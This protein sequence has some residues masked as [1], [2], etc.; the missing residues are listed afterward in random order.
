MNKLVSIIILSYN[1]LQYFKEALDSVLNQTY[2]PIELV[3][4]DDCSI[5]FDVCLH[6]RLGMSL[7][8]YINAYRNRGMSVTI[9]K[10]EENVGTVKN[11]KNAV[12]SSKGEYIFAFGSDDVL[13]ADNSIEE[14]IALMDKHHYDMLVVQLRRFSGNLEN[15]LYDVIDKTTF[16]LIGEN[17]RI[18]L[19]KRNMHGEAFFNVM[20]TKALYKD[21]NFYSTPLYLVEDVYR[22]HLILKSHANIGYNDNPVLKYRMSDSS[23]CT[24]KSDANLKR[25]YELESILSTVMMDDLFD[26]Y[27]KNLLNAPTTKKTILWGAG[28]ALEKSYDG[29]KRIFNKIHYIVDNDIAKHGT[30]FD[31]IEI[32]PTDKLLS[33][34]KSNIMILV[35]SSFYYKGILRWLTDN[36]FEEDK[37]VLHCSHCVAPLLLAISS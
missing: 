13:Y 23:V 30:K 17:D 24:Q 32:C 12:D 4:A 37:N 20:H 34:R 3:I 11:I 21:L 25:V 7:E 18:S 33:E 26:Q 6:S 22:N 2:N 27:R 35:C 14:C 28:S 19:S 31:G 5:D 8:D 9:I 10:N 15:M 1:R 16:E 29:I 36:G